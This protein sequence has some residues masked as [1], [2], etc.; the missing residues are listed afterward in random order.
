[1]LDRWIQLNYGY[2]STEAWIYN[3]VKSTL[4]KTGQTNP[5]IKLS[6]LLKIR[7]I[8]NIDYPASYGQFRRELRFTLAHEIA[9]T[10]F[11]DQS[12]SVP[13]KTASQIPQR[14]IE[15]TCDKIA[16]EILMPQ[17]MVFQYL[18]SKYKIGDNIDLD[19]LP[20]ILVDLFVVFDVSPGVAA[21]RI[22]DDLGL[23]KVLILGIGWR[24][25]TYKNQEDPRGSIDAKKTGFSIKLY[26]RKRGIEEGEHH[27]RLEWYARPKWVSEKLYLPLTGNP[28]IRLKVVEKLFKSSESIK[29]ISTTE[30]LTSFSLGN[31]TK[32]L[33]EIFPGKEEYKILAYI[34]KKKTTKNLSLLNEQPP[35]NDDLVS[36]RDT[37]I[38]A[39]IP[40][41]K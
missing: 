27:W 11:Y 5:P 24:N 2:A 22:V 14:I 37:R 30:P 20:E 7:N 34:Y 6:N 28:K 16:A 29:K 21:R 41:G 10:F 23:C 4:A 36:R 19:T 17:D 40:L 18:K 15:Q 38:M 25:K 8:T 12:S 31:L 13:K 26:E 33:R 35:L 39:C 3:V 32:N 1:M 9:H